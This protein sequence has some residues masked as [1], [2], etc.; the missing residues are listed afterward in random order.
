MNKILKE[1]GK[2][3]SAEPCQNRADA[4]FWNGISFFGEGT[5]QSDRF[6]AAP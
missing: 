1:G 6:R 4:F 2:R 3:P 5:E